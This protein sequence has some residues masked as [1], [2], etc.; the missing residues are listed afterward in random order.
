VWSTTP[1][2]LRVSISEAMTAHCSPP[3]QLD[4]TTVPGGGLRDE[5]ANITNDLKSLLDSP[6]DNP[7]A[8]KAWLA[9]CCQ[10]LGRVGAEFRLRRSSTMLTSRDRYKRRLGIAV[11]ATGILSATII[12]A[13]T[14]I[15]YATAQRIS[16]ITATYGMSCNGV[17]VGSGGKP[18]EIQPGNATD[19]VVKL[20]QGAAGS[21]RA[22]V[23]GWLFGDPRTELCQRLYRRVALRCR[24]ATGCK[25]PGRGDGQESAA[26]LPVRGPGSSCRHRMPLGTLQA[27]TVLS[28]IDET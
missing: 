18:I 12:V 21:C 22:T 28:A 13:A 26:V 2:S 7:L 24:R 17:T 3:Q 15:Y 14:G 8:I 11:I 16:I 6:Q 27:P 5:L 23:S 25:P 19:A 10:F 4:L 20:C 9:A 1:T